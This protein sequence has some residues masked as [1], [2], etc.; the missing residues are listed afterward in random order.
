MSGLPLATPFLPS[1]TAQLEYLY[2]NPEIQLSPDEHHCLERTSLSSWNRPS[3]C[4]EG[5]RNS[6]L[7]PHQGYVDQGHERITQKQ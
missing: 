4:G 7:G 1:D 3:R 5:G 6:F 2:P